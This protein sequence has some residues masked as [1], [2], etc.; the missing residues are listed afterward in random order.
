MIPAPCESP[1]EGRVV[2]VLGSRRTGTT[3]LQELLLAHPDAV[4]V[5]AMEVVPGRVDPRETVIM[6]ALEHFWTN[7]HSD[8]GDG[9]SAYLERDAVIAAMRRFCDSLF[10]QARDVYKPGATW[11]VEKSPSNLDYLPMLAAVYPDAW[12]VHILRD[13]RDAIRSVLATPMAPLHIADAASH[14]VVGLNKLEQS[15]HLLQRF[16]EV[17]YEAVLGDP[18]GHAADLLDWIGLERNDEVLRAVEQQSKREVARFGAQDP[19]GPGK[20]MQLPARDRAVILDIAGDWL[21]ELGYID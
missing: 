14:W 20:W 10:A 3:W 11:F 8:R 9:L 4:G 5:G 13:G 12:Y 2:F 16:R 21:T 6:M 19:I 7:A 18:V 17:R 1:F 15:R